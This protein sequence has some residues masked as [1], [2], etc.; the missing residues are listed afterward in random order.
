M[1][2]YR[3][4]LFL[5]LWA[6]SAAAQ[7]YP[8]DNVP[9]PDGAQTT[10]FQYDPRKCGFD[11]GDLVV[12][13]APT[14]LDFQA[15]V[16]DAK[17]PTG[18]G[19]FNNLV[20]RLLRAG[21][22]VCSET[23][24]SVL[25]RAYT[26]N[27]EI[28]RGMDCAMDQVMAEST[29][30]LSLQVC[31]AG[32]TGCLPPVALSSVPYAVKANYAAEAEAARS[33]NLAAVANYAHRMTVDRDLFLRVGQK[34]LGMGY[35]D[36]A[37]PLSSEIPANL[38]PA[39]AQSPSD[40]GWLRWVPMATAP[41]FENYGW[42][43]HPLVDT[44]FAIGGPQ[45][46]G[47]T[48]PQALDKVRLLATTLR[49]AAPVVY[50]GP[51]RVAS[52]GVQVA[53]YLIVHSVSTS[54]RRLV[55]GGS[56]WAGA[57]LTV[58]GDLSTYGAA[59]TGGDLAVTGQLTVSSGDTLINGAANFAGGLTASSVKAR[60]VLALGQPLR[61]Q[62]ALH[63]ASGSPTGPGLRV[64]TS[65]VGGSELAIGSSGA[66][67][68]IRFRS[69]VIVE[70]YARFNSATFLGTTT[71]NAGC[72]FGR[73][74]RHDGTCV[75]VDE[76]L[77][78][79]HTCGTRIDSVCVDKRSTDNPPY[80][81]CRCPV[82]TLSTATRCYSRKTYRRVF[83]T[84][85]SYPGSALTSVA[86]VNALCQAAANAAAAQALNADGRTVYEALLAL[87]TVGAAGRITD[88]MRF[89]TLDGKEVATS[90]ADLLDGTLLNPVG[91]TPAG[92]AN[93]ALAW[94]GIDGG[95]LSHSQTCVANPGGSMAVAAPGQTTKWLQ[96][97]VAP[98][99]ESHP[100]ICV[101][102]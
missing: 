46:A 25:V 42:Y 21:A 92:S 5:T 16:S 4:V 70:G 74:K 9:N 87:P 45:T 20:V 18:E 64:Q 44:R 51:T 23:F 48:P 65:A 33:A 100:L 91:V 58:T 99:T 61:V 27:L 47:A 24:S 37:T 102:R 8:C 30:P 7:D 88:G 26:L 98:C 81:E 14:V 63:F 69:R 85:T 82:G 76:C 49:L 84:P 29:E 41:S 56:L 43:Y 22:P 80:F 89:V 93:T 6:A 40:G 31:L 55:A 72:G 90:R 11:V 13:R 50:M 32:T 94:T 36:F 67:G 28:G 95:G 71:G 52:G 39:G 38:L 97:A 62:N 78:G 79:T 60:H 3:T 53:D 96:K 15:R 83:T 86:A 2:P 34:Q 35:L 73:A 75:E 10:G 59:T 66:T 68:G 77:E 101:E 12:Q 19:T 17:L 54:V 1:T 57:D